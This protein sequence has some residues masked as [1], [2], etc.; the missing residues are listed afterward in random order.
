MLAVADW[1]FVVG[2]YLSAHR[3]GCLWALAGGENKADNTIHACDGS[4]QKDIW[5]TRF[6]LLRLG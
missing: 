1:N 6:S 4:L 2:N 5:H 3:L